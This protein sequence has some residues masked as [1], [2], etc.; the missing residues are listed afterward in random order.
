MQNTWAR[1]IFMNSFDDH[2]NLYVFFNDSS[3]QN[4]PFAVSVHVQFPL[5]AREL[6]KHIVGNSQNSKRNSTWWYCR[7]WLEKQ[8]CEKNVGEWAEFLRSAMRMGTRVAG[9]EF[10]SALVPVQNVPN[11]NPNCNP[12][13]L[14][15]TLTVTLTLRPE[16]A[17]KKIHW[18]GWDDLPSGIYRGTLGTAK[19][20]NHTTE[21]S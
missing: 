20:E 11:P 13:T 18:W 10:F 16:Q 4:R 12:L 7:T 9:C 19:R 15:L 8:K 1:F 14:T 21:H 2:E 5:N 17:W 6:W 3:S